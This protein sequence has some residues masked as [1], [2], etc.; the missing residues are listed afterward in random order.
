MVLNF[1]CQSCSLTFSIG[2]Y[3][4]HFDNE[5]SGS[6]L[7]VCR[8]CGAQHRIEDRGPAQFDLFDVSISAIPE[9][10]RTT[11]MA[12]LRRTF[13]MSLAKARASVD[14]L[15]F[16]LGSGLRDGEAQELRRGFA[17]AGASVD[18]RRIGGEGNP[19]FGP[20]QNYRLFVKRVSGDEPSSEVEVR[21]WSVGNEVPIADL[22]CGKCAATGSLALDEGTHPAACP[23][24][25]GTMSPD[26]GFVT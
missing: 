10:A 25:S 13:S 4:H 21:H 8:S 3:H 9:N 16:K 15:P 24:C 7:C 11:V 12:H 17:D 1:R 22:K 20:V 18:V 6:S 19:A 5:Y 2:W 14:A 23:R 26:G